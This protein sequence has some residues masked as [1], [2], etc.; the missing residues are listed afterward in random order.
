M[1][2]SCQRVTALHGTCCS[3]RTSIPVLVTSCT[4]AGTRVLYEIMT[5]SSLGDGAGV[6][7][8]VMNL[9]NLV[10]RLGSHLAHN[11]SELTDPIT[12]RVG[13]RCSNLH[14]ALQSHP[15]NLLDLLAS[16]R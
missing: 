2:D 4:V 6:V 12:F 9:A 16:L 7:T 14:H 1:C 8:K 5:S 10:M 3:A 13:L 15:A 11:T